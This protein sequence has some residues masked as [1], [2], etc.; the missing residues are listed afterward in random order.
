MISLP[1]IFLVAMSF[2]SVVSPLN[3]SHSTGTKNTP[4]ILITKISYSTTGGRGGNYEHL[5]ISTDS[6]IYIQARRGT[7][8]A[9]KE[10]T[11]TNDWNRLTST[12]NL[13]DFDNIKSNPGHALYDGTDITITVEV[14]KEKHTI[15]NGNEDT[16]NFKR[17]EPFTDLLEK[18]L[19]ECRDKMN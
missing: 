1:T 2:V 3:C 19:I 9:I 6:L 18:K 14:G 5:D 16:V 12:I 17:I 8:K 15:I 10:K 4:D 7:E 13:D 11:V